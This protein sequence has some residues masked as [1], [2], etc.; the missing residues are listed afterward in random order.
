M[1]SD[2]SLFTF[3]LGVSPLSNMKYSNGFKFLATR[4]II[5]DGNSIS[6]LFNIA[7]Y[8]ELDIEPSLNIVPWSLIFVPCW[9]NSTGM[10]VKKIKDL[11]LNMNNNIQV[12][13]FSFWL[14]WHANYAIAWLLKDNIAKKCIG[15]STSLSLRSQ[16]IISEY[17]GANLPVSLL[18]WFWDWSSLLGNEPIGEMKIGCQ[19]QPQLAKM[20]TSV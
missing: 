14:F 19:L 13:K 5:I 7:V 12:V 3:C 11:K 10:C 6:K 2:F 4:I 15:N 18:W 1:I 16:K 20:I 9:K 17:A 8:I